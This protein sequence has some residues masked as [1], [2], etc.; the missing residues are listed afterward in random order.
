MMNSRRNSPR[1]TRYAARRRREDGAPRL[2]DQVPG[3]VGLELH[4]EDHSGVLPGARYT[5]RVVVDQ[6]PALFLVPCVDPECAGVDH[7][8]TQKVM[9]ALRSGEVSFHGEDECSGVMGPSPCAR[10][11]RFEAVATFAP[12][13]LDPLD[14]AHETRQRRAG[15]AVE[16]AA[17]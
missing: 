12:V 15:R 17:S 11:L 5:R 10:A 7:D 16:L 4:L 6:A 1:M 8:L 3:L 13:R 14:G 9:E 2:R